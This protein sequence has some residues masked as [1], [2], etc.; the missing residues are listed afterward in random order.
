MPEVEID[1][2][3][4]GQ[5]HRRP[6][7][8]RTPR[9]T[10]SSRSSCSRPT[11]RWP[12]SSATRGW[13][14]APRPRRPRP[15]EAQGA[16]RVR[17]RAGLQDREPRKPLRAA[18]AAGRREGR[19]ARACRQLR[20]APLDAAGRLQPR[21]RG[22]LRPG[23]RLLLPLHLADPPLSRPHGPPADRAT[24]PRAR[25]REQHMEALLVLGEHCS[26]RE[27]RAAEA[28]RELN[29]VKLLNYLADKIGTQMNGV[30]TGVESFGL[31]VTGSELP[32]EGFIPIGAPD[33]RLLPLR[34]RRPR[35]PRPARAATPTAWATRCASRW[36]PST[37]IAASSTSACWAGWARRATQ[38]PHRAS[39]RTARRSPARK[40][41]RAKAA[42]NAAPVAA[43]GDAPSAVA[44]EYGDVQT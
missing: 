22:P 1:L 28:E 7:G 38:S 3:K 25:S 15:A 33:R 4:D 8:R 34:P 35:D 40:K 32:A 9:A 36:R 18:E 12:R 43:P 16:H 23:E 6:P 5:R 42:R 27:Q 10:R 21:G 17:R 30:I 44:V 37:S 41:A 24:S 19:P 2:D 13:L 11:R 31:F 39:T 29:K 14:P 26:D 20:G